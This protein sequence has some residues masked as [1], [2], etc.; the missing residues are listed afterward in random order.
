MSEILVVKISDFPEGDRRIVQAEKAEIGV[1]HHK[2]SFYAYANTCLHSG[3]PACEGV[4]MPKVLE[5]LA[6]D[7]TYQGQIFSEDEMHFVCPWHGWEYDIK[8]GACAGDPRM[9]L[10]KYDTVQRDGNLYVVV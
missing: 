1:F 10:R 8:T 6:D 2:G 4:L 3:G 9:K 5:V 7:R